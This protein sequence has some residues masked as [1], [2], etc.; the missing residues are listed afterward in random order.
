[1]LQQLDPL[2]F[3]KRSSKGLICHPEGPKQAGEMGW[4]SSPHEEQREIQNLPAG[5]K[6]FQVPVNAGKPP[7][8]KPPS[9]KGSGGCG[10]RLTEHQP[11]QTLCPCGKEGWWHLRGIRSATLE[12][13]LPLHSAQVMQLLRYWVHLWA[14][15]HMRDIMESLAKGCKDDKGTGTAPLWGK[16]QSCAHSAWRRGASEGNL[17]NEYEC[18]KEGCTEDEPGSFL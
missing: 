1:M 17:I 16:A 10:G 14:A 7:A 3:H 6:Q 15:L 9:R 18:L 13:I 8:R 11:A 2:S 4:Q 12:V 5:K